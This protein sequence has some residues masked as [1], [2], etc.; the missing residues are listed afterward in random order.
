MPMSK[1]RKA[2]YNKRYYQESKVGIL[3]PTKIPKPDSPVQ[4]VKPEPQWRPNK[5]FPST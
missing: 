2:E 3:K 1:E 4:P 5:Y